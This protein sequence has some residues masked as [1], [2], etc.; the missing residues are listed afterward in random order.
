MS[1]LAYAEYLNNAET[2]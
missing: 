2:K 1:Q